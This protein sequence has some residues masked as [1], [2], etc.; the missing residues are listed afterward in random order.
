MIGP[1]S[2][3]VYFEA[4]PGS[5][6]TER[7]NFHHAFRE[8]ALIG[9]INAG[10]MF[11]PIFLV[12]LGASNV[13]VSLLT[14]LPAFIGVA[15]A[16]PI[17][18]F[19]QSRR[20]IVPWYARG[21]IGHQAAFGAAALASLLLPPPLIVPGVLSVWAVGT[22]FSTITN[23]A[24]N[25][26]MN[27]TAGS[28]S[29]YD[30]MSRRWSIMAVATAISTAVVGYGLTR[31][32]FPL[33]FQI[34][35]AGFT[36]AGVWAYRYGSRLIVPDHPAVTRDRAGRSLARRAA[37]TVRLVRAHPAFISFEARRVVFAMGTT[38]TLPLIP[39]YYVRVLEASNSWIGLIGT[40]QSLTVLIGYAFWRQQARGGARYVLAAAT[41]GAALH[42]LALSIT[43]QVETAVVLAGL[44]AIFTSGVS[45]AMF[46]RLM[47]TVPDG[48]G[49]TFNS[50]DNTLVNIAGVAAPVLGALLADRIGLGGALA[51]AGL[52]GLIG[53]GLF[54]IDRSGT[55]TG[56]AAPEPAP[57]PTG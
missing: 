49:V 30:L 34:A 35:F 9:V 7:H 39:L 45:L 8:S 31:L 48:Y 41:F 1:R 38:L 27:A 29:R 20:N 54:A 53:A 32:A 13:E 56:T 37:D 33:N 5:T 3:S 51:V 25:V 10:G 43:H 6:P 22:L 14:A 42:P 19:M 44:G 18:A 23:V 11:L 55:G 15:L 17:G 47:T 36:L 2:L 21:R 52:V 40:V 50:I 16:I 57:Q 24:F 26:V 28:R 46:D 12:R 4:P